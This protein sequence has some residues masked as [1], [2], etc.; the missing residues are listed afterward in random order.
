MI[1]K[2]KIYQLIYQYS[3]TPI[4]NKIYKTRELQILLKKFF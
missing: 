4:R 3:T 2:Y 1:W